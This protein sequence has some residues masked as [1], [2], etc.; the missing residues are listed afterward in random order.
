MGC[1][2]CHGGLTVI[3]RAGLSR[4]TAPTSSRSMTVSAPPP[5]NLA[6]QRA[7]DQLPSLP[8]RSVFRAE[9]DAARLNLSASIHGF[10][11]N[12]LRGQRGRGLCPLSSLLVWGSHPLPA[13]CPCRCRPGLYQLSRNHRGARLGVVATRA[14]EGKGQVNGLMAH[15]TPSLQKLD[16]S[17]RAS[18]GSITRLPSLSCRLPAP[19]DRHDH[20]HLDQDEQSLYRH[21]TDESGRLF[22]AACHSSPHSLYPA[23]NP[24]GAQLNGLQPLQYQ[25][26]PLPLGSNRNCAVCHTV[27]MGDEMHHANILRDFRNE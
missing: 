18:L 16:K 6:P 21:R 8:C 3:D 11:A 7:A 10:H 15:L 14:Q 12:Y 20:Q 5:C 2:N 19:G 27:A 23:E 4:E 1:R 24:Y 26:N 22:C 25:Q 13:R 17:R 9:G